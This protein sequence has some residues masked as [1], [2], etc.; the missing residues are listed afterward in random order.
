[1]ARKASDNL[2]EEYC[3]IVHSVATEKQRNMMYIEK[4]KRDFVTEITAMNQKVYSLE[5]VKKRLLD[6][7][8]KNQKA[9]AEMNL[10]FETRM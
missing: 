6:L 2:Q 7:D 4:A 5:E 3:R 10:L 9:R 1:M 8:E